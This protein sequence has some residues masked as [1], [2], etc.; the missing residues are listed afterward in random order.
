MNDV[1]AVY[2]ITC[3]PINESYIGQS[4]SFYGRCKAHLGALRNGTHD[5]KLLQE[6]YDFFGEEAFTIEIVERV[7]DS[8]WLMFRE[9]YHMMKTQCSINTK[10]YLPYRYP[11]VSII[12]TKR[13]NK[14]EREYQELLEYKSKYHALLERH[15]RL[16]EQVTEV[17]IRESKSI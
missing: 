4:K 7:N 10:Q 5:N 17:L 16:L 13:R 9:F 2:K 1:A 6:T 14:K 15:N 8:D 12:N 11:S 3:H